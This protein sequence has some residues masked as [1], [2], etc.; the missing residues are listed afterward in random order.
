MD[1]K[2][3]YLYSKYLERQIHKNKWKQKVWSKP[4]NVPSQQWQ[5][6]KKNILENDENSHYIDGFYFLYLYKTF[7]AFTSLTPSK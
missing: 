3:H 1:K 2:N 5:A 6:Y 7:F 4:P